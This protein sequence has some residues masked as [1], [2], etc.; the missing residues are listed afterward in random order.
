MFESGRVK[1]KVKASLPTAAR[2]T[3]SRPQTARS[4]RH[5]KD[6]LDDELAELRS[7]RSSAKISAQ[8]PPMMPGP[9]VDSVFDT[10]SPSVYARLAS[11]PQSAAVEPRSF[12]YQVPRSAKVEMR[13]DADLPEG[14][15]IQLASPKQAKANLGQAAFYKP[16]SESRNNFFKKPASQKLEVSGVDSVK[17][18]SAAKAPEKK[19]VDFAEAGKPANKK[20]DYVPG[21]NYADERL[22]KLRAEFLRKDMPIIDDAEF[23]RKLPTTG[24]DILEKN[25]EGLLEQH[26]NDRGGGDHG[27]CYVPGQLLEKFPFP[28]KG[29]LKKD[30]SPLNFD[31]AKPIFGDA[32]VPKEAFRPQLPQELTTT[33]RVKAF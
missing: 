17:A 5:A 20:A 32:N 13:K 7:Q 22:K 6:D 18:G 23:L 15:V 24:E 16:D 26:D 29:T 11:D 33:Y 31:E 3:A 14:A 21:Q 2:G 19:Q 10:K 12:R 8:V 28:K 1:A 4:A 25:I 27:P 9:E 30:H